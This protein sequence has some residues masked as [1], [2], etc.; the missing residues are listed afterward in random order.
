MTT[1]APQH[2]TPVQQPPIQ[3]Q[4]SSSSSQPAEPMFSQR[5]GNQQSQAQTTQSLEPMV[6][7][8]Y[9]GQQS[10]APSSHSM[11]PMYSQRF[12]GNQQAQTQSSSDTLEPMYNRFGNQPY[13]QGAPYSD[14]QQPTGIQQPGYTGGF[15]GKPMM[16]QDYQ[17]FQNQQ[18][19]YSGPRPQ[20][21]Q[22]MGGPQM[23][24]TPSKRFPSTYEQGMF[25]MNSPVCLC[26]L[27]DVCV[28][29]CMVSKKFWNTFY[30]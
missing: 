21:S 13:Q 17:N 19:Q 4:A 25:N 9:M 29:F 1:N 20:M 11:D 5:F 3:S 10:Q 2:G 30:I 27:D 28:F 12:S 16:G 23:Y 22:E 7:Q 18:G 26:D 24:S 15:S 14:Q 6:S 8:R